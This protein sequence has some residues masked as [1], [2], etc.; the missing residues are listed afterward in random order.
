M[1]FES[2]SWSESEQSGGVAAELDSLESVFDVFVQLYRF[3]FAGGRGGVPGG[4]RWRIRWPPWRRLSK[5]GS[6]SRPPW[7]KFGTARKTAT[8]SDGA[9]SDSAPSCRSCSRRG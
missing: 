4:S 8:R 1:I 5:S 7:T 6:R 9:C 3:S 2:D